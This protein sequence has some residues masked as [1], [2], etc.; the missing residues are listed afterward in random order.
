M[1]VLVTGGTGYVGRTLRE[2]LRGQGHDVRL[3]VRKE[4]AHKIG[5]GEGYEVVVGDVLDSQACLKAVDGC[6]AV[7]NLVGII[8]EHP[9]DGTTYVAMHTEA[10]YNVLDAAR[11]SGLQRFIHMS[12]LGASPDAR[13]KYH[14]TKFEAE[15]IVTDSG[16]RWTVFRPSVIFDRGDMF[17]QELVDLVHRRVVPIIDGGKAILQ[18]VSLANVTDAMADSVVKPETQGRVFEVGGP[19]RVQIKALLD[20]IAAHY[21][22]HMNTMAVSS[23]FIK[24]MVKLLQGFKSFPLTVDQLLMLVEDN[25]C[26]TADFQTAFGIDKLDSFE[27]ALPS[28]LDGSETRAA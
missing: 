24:P 9:D 18:P 12:A 17:I 23:T 14:T 20:K 10:T 5:A 4:S 7:V 15:K 1:K 19:D 28:L 3:L 11:R 22:V 6:T 2:K 26:D 8:R 21:K 27:D 16:L 25:V 13:S